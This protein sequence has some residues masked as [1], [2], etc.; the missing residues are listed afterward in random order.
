M[1]K[2]IAFLTVQCKTESLFR[3]IKWEARI[4]ENANYIPTHCVRLKLIHTRI[5][6][7]IE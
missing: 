4:S 6:P 7:G 2:I 3:L 1:F 5:K